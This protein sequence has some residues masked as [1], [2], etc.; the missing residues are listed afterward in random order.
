MT[1]H[2]EIVRIY[3]VEPTVVIHQSDT[4]SLTKFLLLLYLM[5]TSQFL[6]YYFCLTEKSLMW[7]LG[8]TSLKSKEICLS[9]W[10]SQ[11]MLMFDR[12]CSFIISH[13]LFPQCTTYFRI[14]ISMAILQWNLITC[15]RATGENNPL[16]F[17]PPTSLEW[18][19]EEQFCF[20]WSVNDSNDLILSF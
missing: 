11:H 15:F 16:S 19:S 17:W 8:R 7:F 4:Q 1:M 18:A 20:A 9:P 12:C 14:N 10:Q 2:T 6:Q 3:W 5:N 13:L